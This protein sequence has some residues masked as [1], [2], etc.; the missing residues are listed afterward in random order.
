MPRVWLSSTDGYK[1]SQKN[2]A[3]LKTL[4]AITSSL[5]HLLGNG[6][7]IVLGT[8]NCLDCIL[9][10][11][12]TFA[13]L[14][15]NIVPPRPA[16]L[17]ATCRQNALHHDVCVGEQDGVHHVSAGPAPSDIVA[18]GEAAR[19]LFESTAHMSGEAVVGILAAL[20]DVS[21]ASLASVGM[22]SG[23]VR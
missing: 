10:M 8:V 4:F 23:S 14:Q 5:G 15:V 22:Q 9:A 1:L 2:V 11:P 16:L 6:W 3:A 18:L 13:G 7:H 20:H 21:A 12:R 17:V 19:S